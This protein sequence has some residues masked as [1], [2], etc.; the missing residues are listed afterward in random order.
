MSHKGVIGVRAVNWIHNYIQGFSLSF[1]SR[2]FKKGERRL[3]GRQRLR[4]CCAHHAEIRVLLSVYGIR[5]YLT[6]LYEQ[7]SLFKSSPKY[8]GRQGIL[9]GGSHS[10]IRPKL[11]QVNLAN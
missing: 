7:R 11:D 6:I 9:A 4:V 3:H 8:G 5:G 1:P 2:V 10:R